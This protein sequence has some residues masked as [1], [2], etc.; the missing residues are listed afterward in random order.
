M[1]AAG[2]FD[3]TQFP[4]SLPRSSRLSVVLTGLRTVPPDGDGSALIDVFFDDNRETV[5]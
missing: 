3:G 1:T 2:F 4:S 5:S